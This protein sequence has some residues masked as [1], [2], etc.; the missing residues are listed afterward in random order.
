[1]RNS[2]ERIIAFD[3]LQL[4]AVLCLNE[5]DNKTLQLITEM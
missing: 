1:M 5:N 4:S 2:R 3:D